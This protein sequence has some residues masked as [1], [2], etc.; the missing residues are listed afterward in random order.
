MLPCNVMLRAVE[1]EGAHKVAADVRVIF[2]GVV[3]AI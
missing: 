3:A 1:E 2:E